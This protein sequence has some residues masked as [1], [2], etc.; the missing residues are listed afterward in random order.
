VLGSKSNLTL[1]NSNSTSMPVGTRLYNDALSIAAAAT[2]IATTTA[3]NN[4]NNYN[5]YNS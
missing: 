4:N 1:L 5:Y 2:A 3:T